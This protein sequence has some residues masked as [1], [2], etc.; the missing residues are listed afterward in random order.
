[1]RGHGFDS[2]ETPDVKRRRTHH[3]TTLPENLIA[4]LEKLGECDETIRS[5]LMEL[6]DLINVAR[7]VD[8]RHV[9]VMLHVKHLFVSF[10]MFKYYSLLSGSITSKGV[11]TC[12]I[13]PEFFWYALRQGMLHTIP[14]SLTSLLVKV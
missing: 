3:V 5:H 2:E 8:E 14:S 10:A 6:L 12:I 1:M 9:S 13:S 7:S 4:L 11:V